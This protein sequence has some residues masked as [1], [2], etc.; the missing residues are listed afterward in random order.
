MFAPHVVEIEVFAFVEVG[1]RIEFLILVVFL[2]GSRVHGSK[3]FKLHALAL[4]DESE[5]FSAVFTENMHSHRVVLRGRH[6]R[7]HKAFVHEFVEPESVSVHLAFERLWRTIEV[8][9]TDCFVRVL[10]VIAGFVDILHFGRVFAA[11]VL[12]DKGQSDFCKVGRNTHAVGTDIRYE[13]VLPFALD[14]HALV[15]LLR[16]SR[17]AFCGHIEFVA[18]F[19]LHRTRR[20]RRCGF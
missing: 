13:C 12:C 8:Y 18:R 1:H 5:F 7:S 6:L 20:K 10:S 14:I 19:L 11:V 3:A 17:S 15:K 16:D 9:R 4:D 2:D